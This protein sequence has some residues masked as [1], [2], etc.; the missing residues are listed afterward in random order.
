MQVMKGTESNAGATIGE[1]I[2]WWAERTPEA[3]ALLA[4]GREPLKYERLRQL[5]LGIARSLQTCGVGRG[6]RVA[7]VLPNGP[8]MAVTFLGV[9]SAAV[10]APLNPGYTAAELD[11][12][13]T[14]LGAKAVIVSGAH[15]API[16]VANRLNIPILQLS[17]APGWVAGAFMLEDGEPAGNE[18]SAPARAEDVALV[19]HTSGTTA[20]PKIV[21]LAHRNLCAS[22]HNIRQT[23][24][25]SEQDRCLNVMPLFHIHGLVAALLA[26]LSA[27]ASVVCTPGF[28]VADF[29]SW[30]SDFDPT[31][32]TA[33]PTMHQSILA[34]AQMHR[35]VIARHPLRFIRS[36]SAALAPPVMEGLEAVFQAPVIESYGMTEA[37]HQMASNPLPPEARKPGSVGLAAGP[38]IAIMDER[39]TLQ[40]CGTTGEIVIQG[41]NV[42][43]GYA[44]NP[45]A[46]QTAFSGGWF[47][48]GDR[49]Y[50]DG[51]GYL[52]VAGR[53]KELINRG[54][55]KISP[56]EVDEVLLQH[57]AVLQAVTFAIPH[58][59]LGEVVGAA[60]VLKPGAAATEFQIREFVSS[61]LANFKVPQVVKLVSEIPRG[62]TGK[63]QRI[64]LAD[65]LGLQPIDET[66]T[67]GEAQYTAPRNP[68]ETTLAEIFSEIL[69]VEKAG[70]HDSFF[71]LGGDSFATTLLMTRVAEE[72]GAEVSFL[73]FLEEPTIARL[74]AEIET[75]GKGREP[76]EAS[77]MRLVPIQLNGSK[78]PLFCAGGHDGSLMVFCALARYLDPDRPVYG[79]PPARVEEGHTSYRLEDLAARYIEQMRAYQPEGPYHLVG[80]CHGGFAVFEMARQLHSR[81]LP[82]ALL[83]MLDTFHP[84]GAG[85]VSWTCTLA[86]K[87]RHLRWRTRFQWRALA[88]RKPRERFSYLLSRARAFVER[89]KFNAGLAAYSF[90]V[91]TRRRVPDFLH[92]THYAN[93]YALRRYAPRAYPGSAVLFRVLDFWPETPQMGWAGL[94]NGGIEI[95]DSPYHYHG[96]RVESTAR[97]MARQLQERLDQLQTAPAVG[98]SLS[99][100]QLR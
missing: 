69:K 1:L 67:H 79:F 83:A 81:G 36:S 99:P 7:V 24:R 5:V 54:G 10:C 82:V 9:A 59:Q 32:Y 87:F 11:F 94:I 44:N 56:R 8:E 26:S 15:A 75:Q 25:L 2:E 39:G 47:R 45:A 90:L 4:P 86:Q 46:N 3:I 18:D 29:F 35:D 73:R 72:L 13:L 12:Y 92:K 48:T 66:E 57:P 50:F 42:T 6:D 77:S 30:I 28:S 51:D 17:A 14:D 21:P 98:T 68:L 85:K 58:R 40:P 62:A 53:I 88:E 52:F 71:R 22:A 93:A 80:Y 41:D 16:D 23:L 34:R 78:P 65:T 84:G 38:Q 33:V 37:A 91:N 19:L 61:R 27:G 100:G 63:I 76:A 97:I 31:W 20:R 96:V 70:V 64:G 95:L 74:A 89:M 43:C 60:V 55:E 49:G